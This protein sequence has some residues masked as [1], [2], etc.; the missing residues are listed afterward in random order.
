MLPSNHARLLKK[1]A[2]ISVSEPSDSE[3]LEADRIAHEVTRTFERPTAPIDVRALNRKAFSIRHI[4]RQ[5]QTD[6]TST[7]EPAQST[8]AAGVG[9]AAPIEEVGTEAA[10]PAAAV[11][12]D[13][14]ALDLAD[15]AEKAAIELRGKQP[16][17]TFT[18]GNRT[19]SEQASA[20]AENIVASNDRNW[21]TATYS[22]TSSRT[23]LQKWLDDNPT[24]IDKAGIAS[25]LEGVLNGLTATQQGYISKHLTGE[26][27]DVQPETA[28]A[29]AI[30]ND[31]KSLTG[32]KKFLDTEG[33]LVRWHAQF[34]KIVSGAGGAGGLA[35]DSFA[36]HAGKIGSGSPLEPR[37]RASME[38]RFGRDFR[39]V[40][41][42]TDQASSESARAVQAKAYTVGN[43]IVFG[44]GQ[45]G[46]G[47]L[48]GSRLLAHEL[49]H[50]VQQTSLA[51]GVH[52]APEETGSECPQRV[53]GEVTRAQREPMIVEGVSNGISGLLVGNFAIGRG[54]IKP[55]FENN[56]TWANY[57]GQMV[58]NA[59]I[60]W[61][62][63][64]YS[65]CEGDEQVNERLRWQRAITIYEALPRLARNQ[66]EAIRAAPLAE[67]FASNADEAGR[68]QNRSVVIRQTSTS[69]TFEEAE[70]DIVTA[71]PY[72]AC[73]DG[74]TVY[75]RKNGRTH[76]C[77]AVTGTRGE[78][79]PNGTYLIRRQGEAQRTRWYR[80]GRARWYLLEPQFPT[81]RSRMHL[82]PGGVS[83]GCIT[84][85]DD[86]CFDQL[87]EILNSPGTATGTGYDGYPPGNAEGVTNP[88]KTV[89]GV[90]WLL[91]T[92]SP[93]GC[94]FTSAPPPP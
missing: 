27:F 13:I 24:V 58:T 56:D 57:W 15:V 17:V 16:T 5:G 11:P 73:F 3:E 39:S 88:E 43:H 60:R 40:V 63:V 55:D 91:V 4:Q 90:G 81:T 87:A 50:V 65:D 76:S 7:P 37:I 59:N 29:D 28:N 44:A 77:P 46:P 86:S 83:A 19:L 34:K 22:D 49:A 82:H 69:V 25:G 54:T 94:P 78:P 53:P 45:Y 41:V 47:S 21:I 30:K 80:S 35:I 42:H 62:I 68:A 48:A 38:T 12:A 74:S 20:M 14:D 72:V 9:V 10:A 84:V 32:I 23:A 31:I 33:G 92:S 85:T 2:D 89:T 52:R 75:V 79:T 71:Y 66:V 93:G 26:A 61:E 64:G 36:Y 67:Y 8:E 6:E 1:S 51:P 70:A 18:S